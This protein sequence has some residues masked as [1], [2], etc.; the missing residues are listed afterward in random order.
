MQIRRLL[1]HKKCQEKNLNKQSSSGEFVKL[2][3]LCS[4]LHNIVFVGRGCWGKIGSVMFNLKFAN[5]NSN[6]LLLKCRRIELLLYV[7]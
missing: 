3:N 7:N 2:G 6:Y 5:I 1:R 4:L